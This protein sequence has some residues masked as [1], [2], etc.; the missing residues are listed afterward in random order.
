MYLRG[1]SRRFQRSSAIH[2]IIEGFISKLIIVNIGD[3]SLKPLGSTM[4]LWINAICL[5]IF[6]IIALIPEI[7]ALIPGIPF[8]IVKIIVAIITMLA[9]FLEADV[10][11]I[12]SKMWL[13]TVGVILLI[14]G[15]LPFFPDTMGDI[16]GLGVFLNSL[17]IVLGAI[18]FIVI[19]VDTMMTSPS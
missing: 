6:G 13:L 3:Y 11:L 10:K 4:W 14:M 16:A 9:A 8:A 1:F 18:T 12:N 7:N 2:F 5:I 15:L 19:Y 17:K